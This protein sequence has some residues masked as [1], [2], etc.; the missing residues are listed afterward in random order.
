MR[1]VV[2]VF[3]NSRH[4]RTHAQQQQQQIFLS[5]P[6]SVYFFLSKNPALVFTKKKPKKVKEYKIQNES[7]ILKCIT[8]HTTHTHTQFFLRKK[9]QGILNP[10]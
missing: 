5:K 2:N 8:Q 9:L 4:T 3:F 10:R 7:Q 1:I 6:S